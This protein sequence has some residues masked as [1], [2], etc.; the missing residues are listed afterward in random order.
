MGL[1]L[2][3]ISVSSVPRAS[4]RTL[5]HKKS[6]KRKKPKKTKNLFFTS[7]DFDSMKIEDLIQRC[8]L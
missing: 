2:D 8:P 1:L 7:P 5:T 3:R 6:K 4:V